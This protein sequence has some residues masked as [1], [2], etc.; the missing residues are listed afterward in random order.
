V[1][2]SANSISHVHRVLL[3]ALKQAVRWQLIRTNPAEAVDPPRV[4][5]FEKRS[6]SPEEVRSLLFAAK[7]SRLYDV[8]LLAAGT[9]L[10]RGEILGLRWRDV[11]F[12]RSRASVGWSL[13]S[14]GTLTE[15]KTARSRRDISL[16]STV[17]AALRA[18]KARQNEVKLSVGRAYVDRGFVFA[19]DLGGPWKPDSMSTPFARSFPAPALESC[20][21]TTYATRP[22]P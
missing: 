1:T 4:R 7:G 14:D 8:I 13:Q 18:L 17:V 20:A 10:R 15:P 11:D 16:P 22:L 19:N 21:S 12:D 5:A 3:A 6:L 9:G 2:N